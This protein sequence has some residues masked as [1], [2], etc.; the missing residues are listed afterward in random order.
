MLFY[1]EIVPFCANAREN[2]PRRDNGGQ[3]FSVSATERNTVRVLHCNSSLPVNRRETFEVFGFAPRTVTEAI[4]SLEAD[5]LAERR[6]DPLDRRAKRIFLTAA[7]D[8]VLKA[9]DPIRQKF[10]DHL[11]AALNDQEQEQ[12]TALVS[13]LNLCLQE[14]EENIEEFSA[15][16][17]EW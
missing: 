6:P 8:A 1:H 17:N 11:F 3:E 7:G 16:A 4:D 15:S 5:G 2:N 14:L 10:A 9:I 12:L 13:R